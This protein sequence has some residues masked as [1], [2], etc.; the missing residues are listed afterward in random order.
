MTICPKCGGDRCE[1]R[2]KDILDPAND[3][4][5]CKECRHTWKRYEGT[6]YGEPGITKTRMLLEAAENA[7]I[8]VIE[9]TIQGESIPELEWIWYG[10]AGHFICGHWCRFHLYTK[11]GRVVV[12]TVGEYVHPRH[13]QGRE[14]LEMEW[15]QQN[16]Y[17]EDIGLDRKYETMVFRSTDEPC[18]CGCGQHMPDGGR[19]LDFH[20]Y[21]NPI[22]A[23][24]GHMELCHK[25]ASVILQLNIKDDDDADDMDD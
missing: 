5:G 8:S 3:L 6:K 22:A 10:K 2:F 20:G 18:D 11:I 17:G 7:G 16:P 25:W 24:E 13:G 4:F 15:L 23:Q 1:T 9:M 14:D 21:N 12:S 19:E